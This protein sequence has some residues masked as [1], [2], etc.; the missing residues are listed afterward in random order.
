MPILSCSHIQF[1]SIHNPLS[2]LQRYEV[3]NLLTAFHQRKDEVIGKAEHLKL[4]L[5]EWMRRRDGRHRY[6]SDPRYNKAGEGD[7]VEVTKRRTWRE[8]P[9]WLSDEIIEFNVPPEMI[10]GAYRQNEYL[11]LGRTSSG[12]LTISSIALSGP[13]QQHFRVLEPDLS[14][15]VT[16]QQFDH[17]RVKIAL[18]SETWLGAATPH[19]E[20][21]LQIVTN[22]EKR[23]VRLV[24]VGSSKDSGSR[25]SPDMKPGS[26]ATEI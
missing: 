10:D 25:K 15:P 11:Y 23:D 26:V 22:A 9:F 19:I 1:G 12:D 20:A 24:V 6:Y 3:T 13:G 17:L 21:T 18:V 8:S 16:L 4:L 14:T 5:V 7:I 2:P